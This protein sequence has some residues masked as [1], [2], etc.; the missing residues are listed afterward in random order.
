MIK[1]TLG[2][3]KTIESTLSKLVTMQLP[4]KL[5]YR[6]SKVLKPIAEELQRVEEFRLAKINEFGTQQEDGS[7]T[8]NPE[9]IEQFKKEM[10]DL[11]E[12]E[13]TI[14]MEP[15]TVD[16]LPETLVISPAELAVL[17]KIIV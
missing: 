9:N 13:I 6:L 11:Y 15:V 12:E 5:S 2:E 14:P 4:V 3:L 1:L 10:F 17:E 8:V 16:D 7:V